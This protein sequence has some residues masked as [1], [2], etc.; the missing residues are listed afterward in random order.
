[1]DLGTT[2]TGFA[3]EQVGRLLHEAVGQ[4]L[5]GRRHNAILPSEPNTH[6]AS[7]ASDRTSDN[8][9]L[10]VRKRFGGIR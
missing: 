4:S 2:E 5:L 1:M 9:S 8:G 7:V 10:E 3:G 6:G